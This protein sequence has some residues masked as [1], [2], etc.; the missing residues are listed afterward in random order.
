[1]VTYLL[2]V[3][4]EYNDT[5]LAFAIYNNVKYYFVPHDKN[6]WILI[7]IFVSK[8]KILQKYSYQHIA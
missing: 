4:I 3:V 8:Y 7:G 5:Y 6:D 1:M 2:D